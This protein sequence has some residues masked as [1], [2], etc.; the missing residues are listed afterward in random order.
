[1]REFPLTTE[2][3]GFQTSVIDPMTTT[4]PYPPSA[5]VPEA[6]SRLAG[7]CGPASVWMVLQRH[8][9]DAD[10]HDIIDRCR[11]TD[12][13]GCFAVCL[14]E[15]ILSF[16]LHV[17]FHSDVDH[18]PKHL[19]LESYRHVTRHSAAPLSKLLLAAHGGA[20][21]IVSYLAD[22]DEGHFSPLTGS[23]ANKIM[24]AYSREDNMPKTE[25]KKRWRAHEI[26]RQAIIVT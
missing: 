9:I 5:D 14:A 25:F 26:L 22:G 10:P 17:R 3:D 11:Y 20:S 1:M 15:A 21:V 2:I 16:G 24:L 6:L 23:K 7:P 19:E 18:S 13:F 8:E 4:S 12:E